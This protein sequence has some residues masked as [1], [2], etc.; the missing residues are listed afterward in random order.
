MY[1]LSLQQ[2]AMISASDL[3]RPLNLCRGSCFGRALHF[4]ALAGHLEAPRT[5]VERGA[6]GG[7]TIKNVGFFGASVDRF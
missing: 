2:Q 7:K 4:S 5:P 1:V 3:L 6:E